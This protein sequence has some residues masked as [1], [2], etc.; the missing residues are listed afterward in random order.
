MACATAVCLK[1]PSFGLDG[2]KGISLAVTDTFLRINGYYLELETIA[3]RRFITE[4][5]TQRGFRVRQ[6]R[7]WMAIHVNS[8]RK[9]LN[10]FNAEYAISCR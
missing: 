1:R 5:I 10:Y 8:T 2:N 4:S 7:E 6:I 9:R 3:A